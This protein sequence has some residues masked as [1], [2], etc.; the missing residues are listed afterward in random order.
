MVK[1]GDQDEHV[2]LTK[3]WQWLL[4]QVEETGLGKGCCWA[5]CMKSNHLQAAEGVPRS[6]PKEQTNAMPYSSKSCKT[7]D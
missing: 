1:A 3:L 2:N 4:L 5:V 6:N 7:T